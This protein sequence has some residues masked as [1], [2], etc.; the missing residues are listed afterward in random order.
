MCAQNIHCIN[1]SYLQN[2]RKNLKNNKNTTK[3]S[4]QGLF[5]WAHCWVFHRPFHS[6]VKSAASGWWLLHDLCGH[7]PIIDFFANKCDLW[8]HL[9]DTVM[10]Q[11]IT[12]DEA[13][14]KPGRCA[15]SEE[16]TFVP[17]G[18][19]QWEQNV[20]SLIEGVQ[21]NWSVVNE[22]NTVFRE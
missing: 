4:W 13:L 7:G 1:Y 2:T 16:D 17:K 22:I 18:P 12:I 14:C 21:C 11:I 6:F 9:L 19:F 10:W 20:P 3:N 8:S 5:F 15:V